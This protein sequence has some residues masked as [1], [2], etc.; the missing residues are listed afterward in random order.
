M[1]WREDREGGSREAS[2]ERRASGSG[3]RRR[4]R[5]RRELG[6]E[7]PRRRTRDEFDR[8]EKYDEECD[9]EEGTSL[10]YDQDRHLSVDGFLA[11]Y[12]PNRQ[13]KIVA[14]RRATR[15]GKATLGGDNGSAI[16]SIAL[17]AELKAS[18]S[19]A[20]VPHTSESDVFG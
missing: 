18:D 19:S 2:S 4:R 1:R 6:D 8:D 16:A 14:D 17:A 7:T 3:R 12:L 5:R 9:R 10:A 15:T 13:A 11:Q 20:L